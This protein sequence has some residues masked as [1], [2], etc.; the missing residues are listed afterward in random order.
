MEHNSSPSIKKRPRSGD[1]LIL[2]RNLYPSQNVSPSPISE[3]PTHYVVEITPYGSVGRPVKAVPNDG[4]VLVQKK[5]KF[6]R[7]L[8]PR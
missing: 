2:Y 6:T 1:A 8:F 4:W 3:P 5:E 7:N